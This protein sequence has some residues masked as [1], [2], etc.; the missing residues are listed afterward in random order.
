MAWNSSWRIPGALSSFVPEERE[1]AKNSH[2][3]FH[4]ICHGTFHALFQEKSSQQHFCK[5][6]LWIYSVAGQRGRNISPQRCFQ[7]ACCIPDPPFPLQIP[8]AQKIQKTQRSEAKRTNLR[9][10]TEPFR[11]FSQIFVDS[12]KT[13]HLGNKEK[14]GLFFMV[15]GPCALP[16]IHANPP[17]PSVPLPTIRWGGA[18]KIPAGGLPKERGGGRGGAGGAPFRWKRLKRRLSQKTADFR[19]NSQKA[20]DWRRSP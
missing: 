16:K 4:G 7:Q 17:P 2:R 8:K 13:K 6:C 5:P 14:R 11:W 1:T 18:L 19:R 10:Q 9:A 12:W 20:A 15:K 3:K